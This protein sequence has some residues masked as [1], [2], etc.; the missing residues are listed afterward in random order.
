MNRFAIQ[1]ITTVE[2][3]SKRCKQR[4]QIPVT[5]EAQATPAALKDFVEKTALDNDW[6]K[7][8]IIGIVAP[9]DEYLLCP[10][11]F[12][13]MNK[14]FTDVA[15]PAPPAQAPATAAKAATP[16]PATPPKIPAKK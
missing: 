7:V 3:S 4:L 8:T 9:V 12:A 6:V 10:K 5:P 15:D 13:Q 16:P 1:Q 14:R 11:C 2:C